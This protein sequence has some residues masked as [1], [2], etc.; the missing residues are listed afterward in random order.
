MAFLYSYGV[1]VRVGLAFDVLENPS[2]GIY[3]V[4][5]HAFIFAGSTDLSTSEGFSHDWKG[6]LL[7]ENAISTIRKTIP[8]VMEYGGGREIVDR[9]NISFVNVNS[10]LET[11]KSLGCSFDGASVE[12]YEFELVGNHDTGISSIVERVEARGICST[13]LD[14]DLSFSLSCDPLVSYRDVN[15]TPKILKSRTTNPIDGVDSYIEDSE[16]PRTFGYVEFGKAVK[17]IERKDVYQPETIT[18]VGTSI[19]LAYGGAYDE[20]N[21]LEVLSILG[22][23]I[24]FSDV[25]T[26]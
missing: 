8:N 3:H 9:F 21:N 23:D 11:Y 14:G 13:V 19:F 18:P 24:E 25:E 26:E 17:F 4:G 5:D 20:N 16:V 15:T 2:K 6:D 22:D 7:A 1:R 10:N 12:V